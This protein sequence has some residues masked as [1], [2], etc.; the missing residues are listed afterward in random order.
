MSQKLPEI[1]SQLPVF[2]KL[3]T[4]Q[5]MDLEQQVIHKSYIEGDYLALQGEVWPYSLIL[6]AGEIRFQKYSLEGRAL[7]AWYLYPFQVFWSPSLLDGG[8]LPATIEARKD[9]QAC[10]WSAEQ[11]LPLVR[12]NQ[13]ALWDLA[14]VLV[15]RM[16]HASEIV[17]D[18]AFQPVASRLARLLVRQYADSQTAPIERSLTLDEMAAMIGTTPVMVCKLLSRF[19]DDGLINVT[20]TEFEFLDQEKLGKIAGSI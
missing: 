9:C 4:R 11:I 17:E 16:R 13:Q 7:G 3:S 1:L 5:R 20:R 12:N 2:S 10:L 6:L 18:L 14:V 19:A 15:Q 8:P